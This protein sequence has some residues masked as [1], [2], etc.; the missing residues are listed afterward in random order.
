M[1]LP[2]L[3]QLMGAYLHQDFDLTGTVDD[4]VEAFAI[5]SPDLAHQL[6]AEV[7]YLVASVNADAELRDRLED[8]GCQV[9]PEDGATQAWL[10]ELSE[11]IRSMTA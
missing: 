5:E 10:I 6:P 4:N 7:D 11:R 1:D 3:R 9:L 2:A 8:L